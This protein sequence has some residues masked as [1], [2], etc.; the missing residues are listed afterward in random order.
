[1][2]LSPI[3]V[4]QV[5]PVGPDAAFTAFTR[6]LGAWW[7][8]RL[9]PDP[10]TYTGVDLDPEVGGELAMRHGDERFVWGR[11]SAWEPGVRYAQSF[12]L[13]L[14]RAHPT[15]LEVTFAAEEGGT[16]VRLTHGGWTA[17]NGHRRGT[18][19]EWGLLLGRYARHV[20]RTAG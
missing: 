1:V 9:T 4:E 18:F 16:R 12:T 2:D 5:V 20:A 19:G 10:A 15:S 13:A 17:E 11:V 7:D 14:D 6:D 8:P 3:V